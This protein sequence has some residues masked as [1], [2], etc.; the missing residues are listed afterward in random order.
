MHS[1]IQDV[2]YSIRIL[3]GNPG[4]PLLAVLALAIAIGANSAVFTVVNTVLLRPL[5][6]PHPEHLVLLSEGARTSPG[7][8][9]LRLPDRDFVE[10]R[11]TA[12]PTHR[13]HAAGGR[14]I[15]D[16]RVA[17][18]GAGRTPGRA[19]KKTR[20]GSSALSGTARRR[21]AAAVAD[22]SRRGC[23]GSADRVRRYR[24]PPADPRR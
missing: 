10:L 11:R 4:L 14:T 23:A 1:L 20:C 21:C 22:L 3:R 19:R 2:R 24:E 17:A 7:R 8:S 5:P 16:R 18:A 15:A 12:R 13:L 6:Y 9:S